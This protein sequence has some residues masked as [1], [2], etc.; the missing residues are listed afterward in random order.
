MT[1]ERK[2]ERSEGK[3]VRVPFG[4]RRSKLQLSEEEAK[5]L[6]KKGYTTRWINEVDGRIER[7]LAGGWVHV[8]PEEARSIGNAAIGQG[9]TDIG[10]KV[11]KIVSRGEPVIRAYLMKIKKKYYEEDQ[12]AKEEINRKV[13]QALSAGGDNA[14]IEGD[15][16]V[17]Y[18]PGV[19]YQR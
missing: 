8:E 9:N 6:D 16:E 13:D 10:T 1:K 15:K 18:G 11:S 7:A 4:A 5:A 17:T 14:T 12:A 19:T 2:N 3:R